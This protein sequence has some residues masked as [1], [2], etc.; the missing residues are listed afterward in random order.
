MST[1]LLTRTVASGMD[2]NI[3]LI[4]AAAACVA[5]VGFGLL[6]RW[7]GAGWLLL[8]K[9]R[10]P[11]PRVTYRLARAASLRALSDRMQKE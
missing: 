9:Y 3:V 8:T 2:S 11:S 4:V 5:D 6:P 1:G 10:K 7:L